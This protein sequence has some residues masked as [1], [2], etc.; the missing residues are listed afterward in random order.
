VFGSTRCV[1]VRSTLR[2]TR[3]T[4]LTTS[5]PRFTGDYAGTF[6]AATVERLREAGYEVEVVSPLDFRHFGIAYGHGVLGNLRRRPW[7][8]FALPLMLANYRRAARRA[9]RRADVIHAFWLPSGLVALG[10]GR[11]LI[12][13][14]PGSDIEL[15]KRLRFLARRILSRA[16]VVICP[17]N[18]IAEEARRLGAAEPRVISPQFPIP[19]EAREEAAEPPS[20]LFVGR[21]S[22]EKGILDL[23]AAA[24]GM[25]LVVVGDGPLR[26]DVPEALGFLPQERLGER[27]ERAAVVACPSYRE[28]F[29]MV[30]AEAMAHGRPVVAGSVGGLLDLVVNGETGLLVR[31]GDV[32][33]LRAALERLLGDAKLRQQMGRAGRRRIEEY[34]SWGPMLDRLLE[35]YEV[36]SRRGSRAGID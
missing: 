1:T 27:Y 10:L 4:V 35:A 22:P 32:A 12:L 7:L 26:N 21:L 16:A 31:P 30:C 24:R 33:G 8:V 11:P 5:Y 2:T 34:F 14:L 20:V 36:A 19:P 17:S 15:A 18:E 28:G 25:P 3:V 13:Q 23:L 29:G 9:A 6:V